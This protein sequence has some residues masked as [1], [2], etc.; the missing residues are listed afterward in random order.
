MEI[1]K[2]NLKKLFT[3]ERTG[4]RMVAKTNMARETSGSQ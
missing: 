1:N 4:G 3:A 2:F